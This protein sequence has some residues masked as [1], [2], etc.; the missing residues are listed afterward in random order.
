MAGAA[1]RAGAVLLVLAVAGA[2]VARGRPGAV[3]AALVATTVV[4]MFALTGLA[5]GWAARYGPGALM[6]VALGGTVIRLGSIAVLLIVLRPTDVLDG[7][8]LVVVTPIVILA[9]LAYEARFVSTH[10]ESLHLDAGARARTDR[11][12]HT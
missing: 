9:L 7:P 3:T 6:A 4:G 12:D 8:T 10:P 2:W 11:E 5:H 1:L